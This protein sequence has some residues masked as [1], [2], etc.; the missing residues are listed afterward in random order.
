MAL[1][2]GVLTV[3]D[4]VS[5]G[6]SSDKS[7]PLL[8]QRAK[9]VLSKHLV[10]MREV[11]IE[12]AVVPDEVQ[13]IQAILKRWSDWSEGAESIPKDLILTTGGTGFAP[14]DVTPEATRPLLEKE[15]PGLVVAMLVESLKHTP[16]AMLSRPAAGIRGST[17][18]I[19]LPGS[20]KAVEENFAAISVALPHGLA[21]LSQK[22]SPLATQHDLKDATASSSSSL[23]DEPSQ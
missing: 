8:A 11:E 13:D 1:R 2:V 17:L 22:P 3:S 4:R 7:G 16:H 5:S 20:T 23:S 19:N 14:R 21:L 15:C 9:D 12:S 10:L 6:E 18:I